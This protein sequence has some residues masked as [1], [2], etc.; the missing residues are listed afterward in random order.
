MTYLLNKIISM[1]KCKTSSHDKNFSFKSRLAIFA[2][3]VLYFRFS[4]N[5]FASVEH[6]S[7][8]VDCKPSGFLVVLLCVWC[9]QQTLEKC[10]VCSK[11]IV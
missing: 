5:Q 3:T 10:S 6:G 8:F 7:G 9:L 4:E 1:C 2:T 11:P